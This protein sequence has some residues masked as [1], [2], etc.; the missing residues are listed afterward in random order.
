MT[1]NFSKVI[2]GTAQ[3]GM[4]YGLGIWKSELMPEATAFSILDAAWNNGITT[5]DTSSN[6]GLAEERIAKFMRLNPSKNFDLI[7]KVKSQHSSSEQKLLCLDNWL[8]KSPLLR[9]ASAGSLSM[10]LHNQNDIFS[11]I[12]TDA[13]Q[14]CQM[15]GFFSSWGVSAYSQKVAVKAAKTENCQI[16][17]LPF[18]ILNQ[19]FHADGVLEILSNHKKTIHARSIFTQGLLFAADFNTQPLSDESIEVIKVV[20][21][22]SAKKGLTLMQYAMSFALSFDT[23]NSVVVGVDTSQQLE[24]IIG[25]LNRPS[26][27]MEFGALCEQIGQLSSEDVRPERWK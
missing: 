24:E 22:F 27:H 15:Q 9:V 10:L 16:I 7:T 6:Y 1:L 25:C 26:N 21:D 8:E 4:P 14:R 23:L 11:E 20:S 17:Q 2:L 12:V 3:L 13:I 5:L 19:S 18:G